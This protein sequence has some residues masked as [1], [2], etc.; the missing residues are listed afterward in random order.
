MKKTYIIPAVELL[1]AETEQVLAAS[2]V[3]GFNSALDDSGVDASDA[4]APTFDIF[5]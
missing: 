4:L 2:P 5:E 3:A 1:D